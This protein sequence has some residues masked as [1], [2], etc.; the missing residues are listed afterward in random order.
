M[1][2]SK[3]IG[4]GLSALAISATVVCTP[5]AAQEPEKKPGLS[6]TLV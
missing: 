2:I 5:A 3:G 4:L 6:Q 1:K